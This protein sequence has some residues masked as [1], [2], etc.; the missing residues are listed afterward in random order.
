MAVFRKKDITTTNDGEWRRLG[1]SYTFRPTSGNTS[2]ICRGQ[3]DLQR[4]CGGSFY[5][6]VMAVGI[7]EEKTDVKPY[8]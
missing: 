5:Y 2:A 6:G 7:G 1:K 3:K 4:D 8:K